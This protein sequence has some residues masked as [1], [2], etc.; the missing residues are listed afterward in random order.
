M[1]P[2]SIR[3]YLATIGRYALL[4]G[5]EETKFAQDVQVY[6]RAE[7]PTKQQYRAYD[8]GRTKL[9]NHNLRLVVSI[10]KRYSNRNSDKLMDLVQEGSIGLNRAV[11]KFDPERGYKFSTYATWWIRQAVSR[12][13]MNCDRDIRLPIHIH[14]QWNEV[15]KSWAILSEELGRKP[16]LEELAEAADT[17]I[18][19]ITHL[20]QC[21][22]PISSLDVGIGAEKD[23]TLGEFLPA[24]GPL[25]EDIV[26]AASQRHQVDHLLGNLSER[27]ARIVRL[28]HGI[29]CGK[30]HSLR[31]IGGILGLSHQAVRNAELSAM[32]K[33]RNRYRQPQ[34]IGLNPAYH[35]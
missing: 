5:A 10:A 13:R 21:F 25:P 15:R 14:A 1:N 17:T 19:K 32:R 11:E 9:I 16:T 4:T 31:D 24:V 35:G 33:L 30:P 28:R 20:G 8:R 23:A 22:Q 34:Y 26:D 18:D 6:L 2:D 12:A 3:D 29:G 27:D 7:N